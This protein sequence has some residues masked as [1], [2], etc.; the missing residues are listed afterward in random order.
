MAWRIATI[1]KVLREHDDDAFVL[2]NRAVTELEAMQKSVSVIR[3]TVADSDRNQLS[4]YC[5]AVDK[6]ATKLGQ[7]KPGTDKPGIIALEKAAQAL[8][9]M[10][11]FV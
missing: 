1:A 8:Q 11:D 5:D 7:S 4:S 6:A 3:K 2:R 10:A 9:V